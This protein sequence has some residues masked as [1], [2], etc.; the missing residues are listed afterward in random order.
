MNMA[1]PQSKMVAELEANRHGRHRLDQM[2]PRF[3]KHLVMFRPNEG[4]VRDLLATARL[5]IPGLAAEE[6]VVK[7][8]HYNPDFLMALS[9]KSK[10]D[11]KQPVGEGFVA[12]LCLNAPGL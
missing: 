4:I 2:E 5:Q 7:I 11:P 1:Q 10:Y 6:E 8:F 12:M 9:R 3:A